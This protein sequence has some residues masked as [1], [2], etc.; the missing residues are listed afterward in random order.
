MIQA[1]ENS[2]SHQF[3]IPDGTILTLQHPTE[4]DVPRLYDAA[5]TS[6]SELAPWMDWCHADF[7]V[8]DAETWVGTTTESDT[9]HSFIIVNEQD[10]L[11]LGTCGLNDISTKN[12]CANLGYW[13]RTSHHGRGIAP[14]ATR[15][16]AEVAFG[17]LDLVRVEI[18]AAVGNVNSQRVAEKAGATREGVTRNGIV[19]HGEPMDAVLFSLIPND[20]SDH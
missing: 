1:S 8:Q 16:V 6:R 17:E 10:N 18:V 2:M 7:C 3:E 13:V 9:E 12:R 14:A 11:C 4:A 20:L 19:H 5:D 15:K